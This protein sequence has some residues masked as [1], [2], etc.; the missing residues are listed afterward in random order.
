MQALHDCDERA[1]PLVVKAR[2]ERAAI[3]VHDFLA[4]GFGMAVLGFERVVDDDELTASAGERA[5]GIGQVA[6]RIDLVVGSRANDRLD[7][8][9]C[10]NIVFCP[11]DDPLGVAPQRLQCAVAFP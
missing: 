7:D 10:G 4:G 3:P 6:D 1:R 11:A 2:G 8:G 9:S 5:A